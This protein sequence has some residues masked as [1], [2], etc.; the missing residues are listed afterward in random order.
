MVS[1]PMF[2]CNFYIFLGALHY[3]ASVELMKTAYYWKQTACQPEFGN[4][5]I[6]DRFFELLRIFHLS[7]TALKFKRDFSNYDKI[8]KVCTFLEITKRI[9]SEVVFSKGLQSINEQII[10]ITKRNALSKPHQY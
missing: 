8:Y 3:M 1:Q 7:N 4:R 5:L 9:F 6:R 10:L 2:I